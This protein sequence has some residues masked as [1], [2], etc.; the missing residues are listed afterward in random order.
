VIGAAGKLGAMPFWVYDFS[1]DAIMA[2]FV[3]VMAS[4][5]A[6]ALVLARFVF[7]V[8]LRHE[9]GKEVMDAYRSVASLT[10][11]VLAFSLVQATLNLRRVEADVRREA[12]ELIAASHILLQLATPSAEM[13][14]AHLA[15]YARLIVVD[16]WPMLLG[17]GRSRDVDLL[18]VRLL[19][20]SRAAAASDP[21]RVTGYAEFARRLD[22]LSDLREARITA[23]TLQLPRAFWHATV[24]LLAFGIVLASLV[25][26]TVHH[27]SGAMVL[28]CVLGVLVSLVAIVDSPFRGESGVKPTELR[29]A[30]DDMSREG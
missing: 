23:A 14:R 22:G 13:L 5:T 24:V 9:Q 3:V 26:W 29:R 28:S 4:I 20:G 17:G 11:L 21:A 12:T 1:D 8:R 7:R 18:L 2:V 30:L 25:P 6:L 15:S 19:E 27:L 10:A 16:E